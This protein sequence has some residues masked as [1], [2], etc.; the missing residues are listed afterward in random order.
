MKIPENTDEIQL[1]SRLRRAFRF[2][3]S[4]LARMLEKWPV[5]QPAPIHTRNGIWYRPEFIWTDWCPGFYAGMMWLAFEQTGRGEMATS[6][7]GI[8]ACPGIS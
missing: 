2:S 3:V 4:Q 6:G 7:G 8:H 5:N 1:K